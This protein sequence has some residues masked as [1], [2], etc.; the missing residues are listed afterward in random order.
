MQR[1]E[2]MDEVLK[3]DL[4]PAA[5]RVLGV[6]AAECIWTKGNKVYVAQS[7]FAEKWNVPKRTRDRWVPELV[8]AGWLYDTGTKAGKY[9]VTVY[10]L[11]VPET[12][13]PEVV[14]EVA[15]VSEPETAKVVP[16][17]VEV[18]P[19]VAPRVVPLCVESG[20]ESG[21]LSSV[22]SSDKNSEVS[23]EEQAPVADAPNAES[24]LIEPNKESEPITKLFKGTEAGTASLEQEL[25][26]LI[27]RYRREVTEQE[28]QEAL[29][30]V[31]DPEWKP[32][33]KQSWRLEEALEL[34]TVGLEW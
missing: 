6:F 34:A 14:P 4:S 12:A 23:S 5:Q 16:L 3:S 17:S 32:H 15:P 22:L 26:Q 24:S 33:R 13:P 30:K 8:K 9:G 31:L 1:Y 21:S 28:K 29:A 25:D 11:V 19:E 2:Y 18:V 10:R 20:A 7:R 27:E